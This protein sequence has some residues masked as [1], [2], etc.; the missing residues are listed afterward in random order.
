LVKARANCAPGE[1]PVYVLGNTDGDKQFSLTES[2]CGG[3]YGAFYALQSDGTYK[4][5]TTVREGLACSTRDQL[6][7]S[8]KVMPD[9]YCRQPGEGP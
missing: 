7:I 1:Y 2:G 6:G 3:G 5:L 9:T 4:L 8:K